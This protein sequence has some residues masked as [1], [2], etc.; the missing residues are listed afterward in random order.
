MKKAI[1]Y[2]LCITVLVALAGCNANVE[3]SPTPLPKPTPTATPNVE[4]T[5]TPRIID[6]ARALTAPISIDEMP[7]IEIYNPTSPPEKIDS[8]IVIEG[9]PPTLQIAALTSQ[10]TM[11]FYVLDGNTLTK[12][13]VRKTSEHAYNIMLGNARLEVSATKSV[14]L[15]DEQVA[16]LIALADAFAENGEDVELSGGTSDVPQ[17]AVVY[18]GITYVLYSSKALREL[19][20]K[21]YEI[22]PYEYNLYRTEFRPSGAMPKTFLPEDGTLKFAFAPQYA[23]HPR[24]KYLVEIEDNR[25][26]VS[27]IELRW[28]MVYTLFYNAMVGHA[29]YE[30]K[31][32]WDFELTDTEK[33]DF[34]DAAE[35]AISDLRSPGNSSTC[36]M[37][38]RGVTYVLTLEPGLANL[39]KLFV[40]ITGI[41]YVELTEE[42][43]QALEDAWRAAIRGE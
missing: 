7:A 28:D 35:F 15:T 5:P 18:K 26:S 19:N 32:T 42:E 31:W 27:L 25:M 43:A 36:S 24:E 33:E 39:Q 20:T 21:I 10:E 4:S 17:S 38:Y 22:L 3:L 40:E 37:L 1:S 34:I 13:F 9:E 23:S 30:V 8:P 2:I 6:P 14:A 12:S 41:Q 29:K 11:Q 16:K